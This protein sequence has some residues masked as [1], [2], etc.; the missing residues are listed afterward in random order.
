LYASSGN[1]SANDSLNVGL[2]GCKGRGFLNLENLLKQP[3]V[4]CTALCDID[5]DI[6][7]NRATDVEKITGKRPKLYRDFRVLIENRDIDIVVVG[8]PDHW[9]CLPT[10]YACEEGKDVYVEKPLAS[11]IEECNIM[12]AAAKKYNR[13]VQ[14]GQQQRSGEHWKEAMKVMHSGQIGK[15]RRIKFWANFSYG[16]GPEPAPNKPVPEGADYDMWLGPAPKRPFNPNRFHGSWRMF[17]DYGGGL[18][19]DWGVHLIDMG[20]WALNISTFPKTVTSMGGNFASGKHAIETADTQTTMFE[21]D[22]FQMLWEHSYIYRGPYDR[23]YGVAFVGDDATIIASRAKWVMNDDGPQKMDEMNIHKNE[24]DSP[25]N[26]AKDFIECVKTRKNP[27]CDIETGRK[28][29]IFAHLGNIAY[30]TGEKLGRYDPDTNT[31]PDNP[32]AN[33]YLTADYRDPWKLPKI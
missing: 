13:V 28:A 31:F 25:L 24:G 26:H 16:A 7:E 33:G 17:W 4:R 10:V 11:T 6:L 2:I 12:A 19:T 8:T 14:V 5:K 20:L 15:I 22:D 1:F 9:H 29:A 30:R 23:M 3:N 18:M 27:A 32:K 21:F